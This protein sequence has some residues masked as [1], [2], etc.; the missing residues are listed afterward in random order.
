MNDGENPAFILNGPIEVL[1]DKLVPEEYVLIGSEFLL[2]SE[3]VLG[4]FVFV[5]LCFFPVLE[6]VFGESGG[7][8]VGV[9]AVE[10]YFHIVLE[11]ELV[12]LFFD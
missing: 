4:W 3:C 11:H 12:V 7:W 1:E 2:W 8:V 9:A 5:G 6:Y 10:S